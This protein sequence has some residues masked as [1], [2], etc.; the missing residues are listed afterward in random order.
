[1]SDQYQQ[2]FTTTDDHN[3]VTYIQFIHPS[4]VSKHLRNKIL[5]S[6]SRVLAQQ[7]VLYCKDEVNEGEEEYYTE[8]TEDPI[9]E[10]LEDSLI[11]E[12]GDPMA[13]ETIEVLEQVFVER[14]KTH[15]KSYESH[16]V[17]KKLVQVT[18]R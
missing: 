5:E 1:M 3:N 2:T 14:K 6:Q 4:Q 11:E 9:E 7:N 13:G 10:T 16:H 15:S 17:S 12:D 18:G 8:E